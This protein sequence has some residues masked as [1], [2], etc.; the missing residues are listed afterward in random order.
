MEMCR[1][2][3]TENLANS[4]QVKNGNEI[5]LGKTPVVMIVQN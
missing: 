2:Y 4:I 3:A 1:K 5:I